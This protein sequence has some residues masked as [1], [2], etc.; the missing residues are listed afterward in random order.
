MNNFLDQFNDE[1]TQQ[2]FGDDKSSY[3]FYAIIAYVLPILFFLPYVMNNYSGYCKHHSNNAITWLAVCIA[4]GIIR[5]V[6][7][8]IPF[9]GGLIN[10][11]L[12]IAM[13]ALVIILIYGAAVGKAYKFPYLSKFFN[14]F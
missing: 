10:F 9:I 4:V 5:W 6:I 13:L 12:A 14:F 8:K 3:A 11:V 2:T 7:G 1:E